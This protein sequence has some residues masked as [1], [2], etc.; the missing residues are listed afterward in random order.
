MGRNARK[1]RSPLAVRAVA[2]SAALAI[3]GGGLV[4]G[5]FLRLRTRGERRPEPDK[6]RCRADRHDRLPGRRSEALER[7]ERCP[8]R[9]GQGAR[10]IW[11]TRSP[12]PTRRLAST[13]QAQAGDA[14]FVQN[15]IVGPLKDKRFAAIDRIR[16]DIK[17]AGGSGAD[18]LGQFAQCTTVAAAPQ[19]NAGQ[20]QGNNNQGNG[21]NNNGN[22]NNGGQNDS[23]GQN[24]DGQGQNNGQGNNGQGQNDNGQG[25]GQGQGN[26]GRRVRWPATSSTSTTSS[27]TP[28]RPFRTGCRERE[29]RL[30]AAPSPPKCGV[31][32]NGKFNPDN[33]I[34][35]PGVEQRRAPHARLRRQPGQRRL[36]QRRRPRQRRHHLP[37]P[38][39]QVDLLLAGAAP[40]ERPGRERRRTP[41][42]AATTRTSARS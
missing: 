30:R 15:A 34:V 21:Q 6:G 29:L 39:R 22:Q 7:A 5:E 20:G 28:S 3:G 1:R 8:R 23:Q 41:T 10:E 17:R 4:C 19:T 36:R 16:I 37:E 24:N 31:N 33:V 25:Q 12:R 26:G 27:P 42:A 2:A 9:C 13:R 35:A 18:N 32:E 11:T 38:G 40:A 14:S